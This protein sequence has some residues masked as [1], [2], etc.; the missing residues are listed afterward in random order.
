M[1]FVL[2]KDIIETE[3][4]PHLPTAKRGYKCKSSLIELINS[5]LYKLKT[6]VQWAYL[7]VQSLFSNMISNY[8]TVFNRY[9]QW[10][11]NEP[12]RH[13]GSRFSLNIN[14]NLIYQVRT[15]TVATLPL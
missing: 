3:I 1:Y 15:L 4:L 6:G 5:I 14:P 9:R 2:N 13:V 7:P 11:K 8:K 10:C 12:G